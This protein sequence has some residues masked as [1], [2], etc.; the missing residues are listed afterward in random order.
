MAEVPDSLIRIL[1]EFWWAM[2]SP[3]GRVA[4]RYTLV[5]DLPGSYGFLA[6]RRALRPWLAAA[7]PNLRI[8]VGARFR[9][10]HKLR[11][12]ENVTIGVDNF[13]QAAGG[14]AIGDH[15]L[16][17]PGVK[18]WSANHVYADGERLIREQGFEY[19]AVSIGRD[20]WIGANAF[21][22]PGTELGDG[23]I[24]AAGSV[25]GAKHYPPDKILAGNPARVIG[26]RRRGE[27]DPGDGG[28]GASG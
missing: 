15:S 17:G 5:R 9:N 28:D 13:L 7:G 4:L 23:C 3:E 19:K 10:P 1:K 11:V 27:P 6:R 26:S 12:G 2:R 20:V 25:V 24:V 22:M 8:H 21:I 16:L 14:I 18:I